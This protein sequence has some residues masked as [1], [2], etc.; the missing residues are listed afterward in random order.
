MVFVAL[1]L[2]TAFEPVKDVPPSDTVVKVAVVITPTPLIAPPAL[3]STAVA[4]LI[5]FGIDSAAVV[6]AEKL[7]SVVVP[8]MAPPKV[9]VPAPESISKL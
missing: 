1:K 8:P 4:V 6:V 2:V 3:K 7:S 9:M 5:L